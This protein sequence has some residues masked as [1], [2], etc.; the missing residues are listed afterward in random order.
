MSRSNVIARVRKLQRLAE[1][2]NPHE[3]AL[4][5]ARAQ[6]LIA[7]YQLTSSDLEDPLTPRESALKAFEELAALNAQLAAML[8]PAVDV[9]A[10]AARHGLRW[11]DG[12]FTRMTSQRKTRGKE[13]Q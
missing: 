11:E 6:A 9:E 7:R 10:I 3:A 2:A 12:K 1:S 4:A 13:P 5:A 8:R